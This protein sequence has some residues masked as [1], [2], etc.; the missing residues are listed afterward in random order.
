[1]SAMEQNRPGAGAAVAALIV[2]VACAVALLGAAPADAKTRFKV[3]GGGF[4]HGVGMSQWGAYGYAKK[5]RNYRKIAT[6]YYR[7]T[8]VGKARPRPIEVLLG[9]GS[10]F[11]F[12]D[13]NK[14]CGK[15]LK[16]GRTYRAALR[17]SK[18]RLERKNGKRIA[19]C[20]SRLTVK[21]KG[22]IELKGKGSYRG[23]LVGKTSG[24]TLYTVNRVALDDYIQGVIPLEMPASWPLDA[25]RAQALAARSY[26]LATDAGS[27]L[28]DQYD[29]TRSQVYGGA[30]AEVAKT[31]RAV[32]K[33]SRQVIEYKGKVIPAFFFS[34]S[35]GRTENV[36]FGFP[37]AD[38]KP[39][40]K[41]VK[42]PFDGGSP[43][44]RWKR[45][46]SRGEMQ[47]KLSG[48]VKGRFKRI[49]VIKRGVSPRIVKAKVVGSRGRK[50]ISGPD[51]RFRLGLPSAWA[52]FKKRK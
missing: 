8:K 19:G 50:S 29:D 40:L 10:S 20:G 5:G 11:S 24:G 17:G 25:L 45:T 1:M 51:L 22:P 35:G 32:R 41:S 7:G 46:F 43:E 47:S 2:A 28:F 6:H 30:S 49:D 12:T 52:I 26:A 42:D 38:P 39:Y 3:T 13:A 37:G 14:A 23:E 18:V 21:G 4:G 48:Y 15:R 31:N 33:S 27:G 34:A 16:G 36:E 9:T 44:H